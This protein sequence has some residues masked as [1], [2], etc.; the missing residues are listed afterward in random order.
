[1]SFRLKIILGIALIEI[2]LVSS[3][4]IAGL[5]WLHSSNETELRD[6]ANNVAQVLAASTKDAVLSYDIATLESIVSEVLKTENIA[7]VEIYNM[8]QKLVEGGKVIHSNDSFRQDTTINA[9]HDGYFDVRKNIIEAGTIFGYVELGISTAHINVI[10]SRAYKITIAIGIAGILTSALFSW[11]LGTY[12]TTRLTNLRIAATSIKEGELGYQIEFTGNDELAQTSQ[13]FNN[14]SSRIK[15]LYDELKESLEKSKLMSRVISESEIYTNTVINSISDVIISTDRYGKIETVNKAVKAIFGYCSDEVIGQNITF[16]MPDSKITEHQN[17]ISNYNKLDKIERGES[18]LMSAKR[19][20]YALHK[21]GSSLPVEVSVTPI[22]I[23]NELIFVGLIT[24]ITS[25]KFAEDE[26]IRSRQEAELASKYKGEF[27]ANMSHEIRTPM[28]GVIGMLQLLDKTRL[29]SQQQQYVNTAVSSADLL[30]YI[31]NDILD[32]SKIEAGKLSLDCVDFDIHKLIE[33]TAE[34][35][36]QT[37]QNKKIEVVCF[38]DKSV[39][40]YVLGDPGRLTQI[41][42]NLGGNAIKFTEAGEI[43]MQV[44]LKKSSDNLNYLHFEVRDT[45][46]GISEKNLEKLFKPF[47]QENGSTSRRFGGSGLGL[48]ICKHLVEMMD[49]DIG[50]FSKQGKGS[51]FWFNICLGRSQKQTSL[52]EGSL[53]NKHILIVDDHETSLTV[54]RAYLQSADVIVHEARDGQQAIDKIE[55]MII[56]ENI[57]LDAIIL[58]RIMPNLD[59]I[60][61]AR[62]IHRNEKFS[63]IPMMLVSS[64]GIIESIP[65]DSGIKFSLGKPIRQQLFL[66]YVFKL[67]NKEEVKINSL[68]DK[69]EHGNKIINA[70]ILLVEDNIVNQQVAFEMLKLLGVTPVLAEN[71][72]EAVEIFKMNK[73]DLILMD[74]Q[75]PEMDGYQ[76]TQLIREIEQQEKKQR[77]VI[78]ALTANAIATDKQQCLD[79]GM[80]DYIPKPITEQFLQQTICKWLETDKNAQAGDITRGTKTKQENEQ[81][82]YINENHYQTMYKKL[83]ERYLSIIEKYKENALL[84][85]ENITSA[86]DKDDIDSIKLYAHTL[87]GSSDSMGASRLSQLASTIEARVAESDLCSISSLLETLESDYLETMK[88]FEHLMANNRQLI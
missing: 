84:I 21:D 86:V 24:D 6:R 46:I 36:S 77:T 55:Q 65:K 25:R 35:L 70:K 22:E 17:F 54:M 1:M 4:I 38:I 64:M 26:M 15:E 72:I 58:D 71:G 43:M 60:E 39:P 53:A 41:L 47:Q 9:V 16:L 19:D 13:T 59:G 11:L 42:M 5:N 12:L 78:I 49:G 63:S 69:T 28:N 61:T 2:V 85:I 7:Y 23:N 52:I 37:T 51:T 68:T 44:E 34:L 81:N 45:G 18:I 10:M 20:L 83:G 66:E 74:C 82:Q 80:D 40:N 30:L 75:M 56:N 31:I 76:A 73:F 79:A 87:K 27:L 62:I 32:F 3:L 88:V 67:I 8:E 29:D 50:I 48:S 33:D 57:N 14:M